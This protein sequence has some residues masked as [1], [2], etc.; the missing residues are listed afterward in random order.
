MP[1]RDEQFTKAVSDL[2]NAL[3]A[4]VPLATRLRR[5]WGTTTQDAVTLEAA[6]DRV[7]RAVKRMQPPEE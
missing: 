7:V 3:Q 4:V 1:E 5:E 2:A 6:I